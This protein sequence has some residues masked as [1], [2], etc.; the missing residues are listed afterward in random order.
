MPIPFTIDEFLSVFE[1]YNSA[2]RPAQVVGYVLA[3]VALYLII[4]KSKVSGLAMSLFLGLAWIWTGVIYHL[5]FFSTIN[6]AAFLFGT[7]FILQGLLIAVFGGFRSD[8]KFIADE[9]AKVAAGLI[10][11]IYA[12]V[13]Y[14]LLAYHSGHV[15]P[16][17]P[18]FPFTPC[19]LTIFTFGVLLLAKSPV[20]W[21]L[22]ITP[23]LWSLVGFTAALRLSMYEDFGLL[24]SGVVGLILILHSNRMN[25]PDRDIS[26]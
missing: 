18:T 22:W 10:L 25:R 4:R 7:L 13:L 5:V 3:A 26:S 14:P 11:I 20:K 2:I 9:K 12:M 19:P 17:S 6:Q 8:L 15:Y 16:R 24:I 23:F 21:Y 1:A